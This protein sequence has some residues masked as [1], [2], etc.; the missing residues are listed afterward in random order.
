MILTDRGDVAVQD[1]KAGDLVMTRDNGLQPLRWVGRQHIT[2]ARLMA[3]PDLQ[4]VRIAIGALGADGPDRS[5]LVSPQHRVLVSGVR[6]E[7]LFGDDEVL[8][9]A[10]HL[11]GQA[12]VTRALPDEGVT[13]I[14]IL[15]D[16]H[17]IVQSDGLWT[18]SF[19]PAER[20]LNAM[21]AEVRDEILTIFP[22]L[23]AIA[24]PGARLSLKSHEVRVL[25]CR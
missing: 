17:E 15:F 18:E 22:G 13:Y 14:H 7:L 9:A 16:R 11:I 21:E 5:M 12:E 24:F 19:Q 25:F 8:V 10:K 23:G 1:L 20:T 4:P 6:A 2:R 3:D